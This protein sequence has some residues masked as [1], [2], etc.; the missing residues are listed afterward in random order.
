MTTVLLLTKGTDDSDETFLQYIDDWFNNT[1]MSIV[2]LDS[3]QS[4]IRCKIADSERFEFLWLPNKTK[5]INGYTKSLS[6]LKAHNKSRL[7]KYASFILKITGMP[8]LFN[9][10]HSIKDIPPNAEIIHQN[11]SKSSK[12]FGWAKYLT[13]CIYDITDKQLNLKNHLYE[14]RNHFK[15]FY[16]NIDKI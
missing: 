9:I 13:Y 1:N 12:I 16:I 6:I 15:T 4:P 11:K 2:V 10:V 5:K 3:S 7:F 8:F 14:Q